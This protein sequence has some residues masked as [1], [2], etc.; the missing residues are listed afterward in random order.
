[1]LIMLE[2]KNKNKVEDLAG[3]SFL[4]FAVQYTLIIKQTKK[5][6]ND[7]SKSLCFNAR[8]KQVPFCH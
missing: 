4:L 5:L 8:G 6:S 2:Q 3:W 7:L 1:M